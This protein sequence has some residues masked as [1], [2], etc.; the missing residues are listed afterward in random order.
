MCS[1]DLSRDMSFRP[2]LLV[3]LAGL[4]LVLAMAAGCAP[5]TAEAV[6]TTRELPTHSPS[7][8]P[9]AMPAAPSPTSELPTSSPPPESPT[10]PPL[11][12]LTPAA[13]GGAEIA[14]PPQATR[15]VSWSQADLAERLKVGLNQVSVL[16]VESVE[17]RDSSLGCPESGRVYLQVITPGYRIILR[18]DGRQFE[19]HSARGRDRAILCDTGS[20][21]EQHLPERPPSTAHPSR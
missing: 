3:G 7:P 5:P 6:P 10:I 12:S 21:G 18:A 9:A 17:W 1:L 14:I 2:S 15:A 13:P 16:S 4:S 11:P 19:Y 20:P 8:G